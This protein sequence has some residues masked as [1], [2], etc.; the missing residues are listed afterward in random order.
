MSALRGFFDIRQGERRNTFAAFATLL[1]ITTGHTMLETAR[2]AFFLAKMPASRLPVMYLVIVALALGLSQIKAARADSKWGVAG[3][4]A[5]A[6]VIT[7]AFWTMMLGGKPTH[8][9][10]HALYVWTG[11]FGS[12]AMLQVWTLLG[13]VHTMTQ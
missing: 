11:L 9:V 1:A 8:T 7:V 10:L 5:V 3:S 6:A 4:L 12:W 13:R 2:D